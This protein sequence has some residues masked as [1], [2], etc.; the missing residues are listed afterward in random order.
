MNDVKKTPGYN[1]GYGYG[2]GY[3]LG[4]Y[5]DDRKNKKFFKRIFSAKSV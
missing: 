1:S 4:Y 2:Y 5:D 3:G